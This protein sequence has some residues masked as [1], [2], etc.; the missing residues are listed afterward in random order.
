MESILQGFLTNTN[1]GLTCLAWRQVKFPESL[2]L[3][4]NLLSKERRLSEKSASWKLA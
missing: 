3:V 4:A 1:R 2:V